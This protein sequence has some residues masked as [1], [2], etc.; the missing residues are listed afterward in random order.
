MAAILDMRK[1][2]PHCPRPST[3]SPIH[4]RATNQPSSSPRPPRPRPR[5]LRFDVPASRSYPPCLPASLPP[6]RSFKVRT[7]T[8]LRAN[9]IFPFLP[10]LFSLREIFFHFS[11]HVANEIKSILDRK[12]VKKQLNYAI[13]SCIRRRNSKCVFSLC[14]RFI[15]VAFF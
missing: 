11:I 5:A 6:P 13:Q 14:R 9:G 1:Y 10:C 15:L 4:P 12:Q 3:N 8:F 7:D 2:P